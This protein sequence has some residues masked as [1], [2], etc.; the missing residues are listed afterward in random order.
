MVNNFHVSYSYEICGNK[1]GN[2]GTIAIFTILTFNDLVRCSGL[3]P[4]YE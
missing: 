1:D 4:W 3:S 2:P